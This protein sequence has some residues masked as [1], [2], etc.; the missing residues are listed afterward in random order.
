MR[1]FCRI[2]IGISVVAFLLEPVRA[3]RRFSVDFRNGRLAD[4]SLVYRGLPF[5]VG[6]SPF[7][8]RRRYSF[9]FPKRFPE[10]YR[11]VKTKDQKKRRDRKKTGVKAWKVDANVAKLCEQ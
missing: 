3:I 11:T 7:G 10:K 5:L 4:G 2:S 6:C 9:Y 8:C 1:E